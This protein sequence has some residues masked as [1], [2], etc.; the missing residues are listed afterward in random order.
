MFSNGAGAS[1]CVDCPVGTYRSSTNGEYLSHCSPCPFGSYSNIPA[2]TSCKSCNTSAEFCA[3]GAVAPMSVSVGS[4]A[5]ATSVEDRV[6]YVTWVNEEAARASFRW[7]ILLGS[8]AA[9]AILFLL[10]L[11]VLFWC[12]CCRSR[13]ARVV[14]KR[15]DLFFSLKHRVLI[16]K[17]VVKRRT[18]AG[19]LF[20]LLFIVGAIVI[21][22]G[23][24]YPF[25]VLNQRA[26]ESLLTGHAPASHSSTT[27][28]V[29][30]KITDYPDDCFSVSVH[31]SG[32][33]HPASHPPFWISEPSDTSST[34]SILWTCNNCSLLAQTAVVEAV[35]SG[36]SA[37]ASMIQWQANCTRIIPL[38]SNTVSGT[39]V[40]PSHDR[41]F[42]G[43]ASTSVQVATVPTVFQFHTEPLQVGYRLFNGSVVHGSTPDQQTFYM[44]SGQVKV[45]VLFVPFSSG[46][47]LV[48]VTESTTVVDLLVRWSSLVGALMPGLAVG[49]GLWEMCPDKFRKRHRRKSPKGNDDDKEDENNKLKSFEMQRIDSSASLGSL[50]SS[51]PQRRLYSRGSSPPFLLPSRRPPHPPLSPM[52]LRTQRS[53]YRIPSLASIQAPSSIAQPVVTHPLHNS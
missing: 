43:V 20:S 35:W 14:L 4:M 49:L 51:S 45:Q 37:K 30:L 26:S 27:F 29:R 9:C 24:G 23:F 25:F 19:G 6:D 18:P 8:I 32:F 22:V 53:T 34:C 42:R 38:E 7:Q 44:E 50:A 17:P 15:L 52:S 48:T 12:C 3:V 11:V 36:L 33:F 28:S 41:T 31:S 46:Y 10:S 16:D 47:A 39:A 40:P 21:L 1:G 5:T 2:A 13:S